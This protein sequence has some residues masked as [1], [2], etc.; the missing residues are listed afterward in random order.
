MRIEINKGGDRSR[1]SRGGSLDVA[2]ISFFIN[3]FPAVLTPF[4]KNKLYLKLRN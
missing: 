3:T 1:L 2:I 4:M